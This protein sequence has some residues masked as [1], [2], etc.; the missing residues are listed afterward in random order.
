[1]TPPNVLGAPKPTSSVMMSSTLGAPL[2]GT[3]VGGHQT[4]DS[5]STGLISPPNF[6]G[7][8]GRALDFSASVYAGAPGF[9]GPS[10]PPTVIGTRNAPTTPAARAI[11]IASRTIF[12][13]TVSFRS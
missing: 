7:T 3:T 12:L 10:F 9:A 11:T 6:G 4:F 2:G 1:M 13:F 8:G 5:F